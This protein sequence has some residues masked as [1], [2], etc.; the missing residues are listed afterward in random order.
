MAELSRHAFAAA[1]PSEL[2]ISNGVD[3][4]LKLVA[5]LEQNL[6]S[7]TNDN[8]AAATAKPAIQYFKQDEEVFEPAPAPIIA[9]VPKPS[10]EHSNKGAKLVIHRVAK[11]IAEPIIPEPVAI[12]ATAEPEP[13]LVENSRIVIIR[14]K[15]ED[16]SEV[17]LLD[18]PNSES[19]NAA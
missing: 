5:E 12:A 11:P 7:G 18:E 14:R 1:A 9:A 8:N 10:S 3:R 2:G 19:I 16:V 4:V 17:P 6:G 15:A 13:K